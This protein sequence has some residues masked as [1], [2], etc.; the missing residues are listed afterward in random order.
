MNNNPEWINHKYFRTYKIAD[1]LTR[2]ARGSS[3][4]ID[5]EGF[6]AN[7]GIL[8]LVP[9]WQKET[10][11]HKLVQQ[12]ADDMFIDDTNGPYITI[13]D[14]EAGFE[15]KRYLPVDLSLQGYGIEHTP[16]EIPPP[17]GEVVRVARNIT[18]WNESAKVADACYDYFMENLRLSQPY[19]GLLSQIA[20]EVFHVVFANRTTMAGLNDYL[21]IHLKEIGSYVDM[22]DIEIQLYFTKKGTLKRKKIPIWA[23]RAVFFREHGRCA[24]CGADVSGLLDALPNEQFDHIIPLANYGLNDVSNLQMLCKPCNQNKS[25][26]HSDTSDRYRRWYRSP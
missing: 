21:A 12:V 25:D 4:A 10:L 2:F 11:V 22:Q 14:P 5:L 8:Q 7:E 3:T 23:K 26:S 16:F 1:T 20:E 24:L 15:P 18:T 17:D 13:Y 9:P 6:H 19:E